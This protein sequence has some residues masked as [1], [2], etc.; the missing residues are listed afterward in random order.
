MELKNAVGPQDQVGFRELRIGRV[1]LNGVDGRVI[2][3]VSYTNS[4]GQSLGSMKEVT[5]CGGK[6]AARIGVKRHAI[7]T[8]TKAAARPNLQG[9]E[10]IEIRGISPIV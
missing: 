7:S 6:L 8:H 2:D 1:A 9:L 3:V 10:A 4:S 5:G